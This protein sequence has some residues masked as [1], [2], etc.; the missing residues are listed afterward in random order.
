MFESLV[1][2]K[3]CKATTGAYCSIYEFESL[4]NL[5]GCKAQKF[6]E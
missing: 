5:K 2:L 3:G 4:V 6:C 1:N